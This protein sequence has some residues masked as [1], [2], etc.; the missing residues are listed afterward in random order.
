[1]GQMLLKVILNSNGRNKVLD[2][3]SVVNISK[4]CE[5]TWGMKAIDIFYLCN[6]KWLCSL[7]NRVQTWSK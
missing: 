3:L 4:V 1:M 7:Y 6:L 2:L 5:Q